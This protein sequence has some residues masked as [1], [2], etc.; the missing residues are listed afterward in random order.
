MPP[1]LAVRNEIVLVHFGFRLCPGGRQRG[2]LSSGRP[3][4]KSCH[5]ERVLVLLLA[6]A[7]DSSVRANP[8]L[9]NQLV[10]LARLCVTE[11]YVLVN[12]GMTN[13]KAVLQESYATYIF[14]G[15][16]I[17]PGTFPD[18][19]RTRLVRLGPLEWRAASPAIGCRIPFEAWSRTAGTGHEPSVAYG[20]FGRT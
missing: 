18:V 2:S 14:V 15:E 17:S 19:S 9:D 10:A 13:R 20:R 8:G 6:L 16:T 1:A 3:E 7:I 4:T 11:L 5:H 12:T